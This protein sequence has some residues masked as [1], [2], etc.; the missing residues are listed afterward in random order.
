MDALMSQQQDFVIDSEG[1]REPVEGMQDGGDVII[2]PQSNQDPSSVVL[3]ILKLLK[4]LARDP[5]EKCA[6]VVQP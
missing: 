1:N 4:S 3:D 6:A 2:L 5:N